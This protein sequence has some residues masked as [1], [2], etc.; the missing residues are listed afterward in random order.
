M[1]QYIAWQN[2]MLNKQKLLMENKDNK[3]KTII[4]IRKILK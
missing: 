1:F 3:Y 4:K 2:K